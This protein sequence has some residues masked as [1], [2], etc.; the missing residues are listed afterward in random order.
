MDQAPD[1]DKVMNAIGPIVATV[2]GD[3]PP[4]FEPNWRERYVNG[5]PKASLHNAH[6]GDRG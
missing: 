1:P 2:T 6:A 3:K 5:R 4:E